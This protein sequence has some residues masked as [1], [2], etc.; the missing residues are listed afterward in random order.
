M[1]TATT[2]LTIR[3][4]SAADGERLAEIFYDAFESIAQSH[5]F[6]VEPPSREFTRFKVLEML[7]TN[8]FAGL[9]AERDGE[10][11]GSAFIDERSLIAGVGPVTVDPCSQDDGIGR[12]LMEA[13][14]E[15]ERDRA[16]AGV[17]L[18][19]TAYHY[20]SLALYAKLGFAIR[21]P[22]SVVQGA[23]PALTIPG[24]TV[25][26]G[27]EHDLPA[28]AELCVRVHGHDRERELRDAIAAGTARVAERPEGVCG[29]A[30]GFGYGWHAVAETNDDLFALLSSAD[31]FIGLGVLVP[32]RNRELLGWCLANG[33]RIV[34]Q[35]TLMTIGLYNEPA[36][37]YL[38]SILF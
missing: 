13:A 11:L 30:T 17:R 19:Q 34:Q 21:E 4:A 6:P 7:S 29:Y 31:A 9:V 37:A 16:A 1:R 23:P 27:A 18:I 26:P 22:L 12:A 14:L 8:R 20:R 28:C 25:R 24:R 5:S 35:S 38:P 36:G 2:Q 3:D 15:R 10:L 32:S 33:L